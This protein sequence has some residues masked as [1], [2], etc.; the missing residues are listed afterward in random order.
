MCKIISHR[1]ACMIVLWNHKGWKRSGSSRTPEAV[2]LEPA[3]THLVTL[4]PSPSLALPTFTQGCPGL[5]KEHPANPTP[6]CHPA[7]GKSSLPGSIIL[8]GQSAPEIKQ[9]L[10]FLAALSLHP[11]RAEG[12]GAH[13]QPGPPPSLLLPNQSTH[14]PPAL[15]P[16]MRQTYIKWHILLKVTFSSNGHI[17]LSR[18]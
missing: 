18:F 5:N 6:S 16:R 1:K 10:A 11:F 3:Q 9:I 7:S 13:P 12:M 14:L 4:E 15:A 2:C 8:D 17:D